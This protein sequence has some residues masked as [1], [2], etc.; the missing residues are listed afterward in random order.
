MM[1]Q[2]LIIHFP[3][4]HRSIGRFREVKKKRKFQTFI[5]KVVA[6]SYERR[7]LTRGSKYSDLV[8]WELVPDRWSQPE[9]VT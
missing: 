2:H 1:L 8:F 9:T 7:S 3:L 4:N 6:V 5:L